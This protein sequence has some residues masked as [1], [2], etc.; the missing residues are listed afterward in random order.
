MMTVREVAAWLDSLDGEQHVAVDE[1]GLTLVVVEDP[2]VY[3]EVGGLPD[4]E[5]ADE[6]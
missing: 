2:D 5:E 1:G 4:E 3:L 6:R